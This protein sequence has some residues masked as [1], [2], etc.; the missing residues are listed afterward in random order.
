MHTGRKAKLLNVFNNSSNL[1]KETQK[2]DFGLET[3]LELAYFYSFIFSAFNDQL[4]KLYKIL[5]RVNHQVSKH[6][7]IG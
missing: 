4:E 2:R 3:L 7:K 1:N 5:E 6:V